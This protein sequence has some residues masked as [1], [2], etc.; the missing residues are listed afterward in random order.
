M[1][2][3]IY[4]DTDSIFFEIPPGVDPIEYSQSIEKAVNEGFAKLSEQLNIKRESLEGQ[5]IYRAELKRVISYFILLNK[6]RY[7]AQ[8]SWEEGIILPE[9][10]WDYKGIKVR[11]DLAQVSYELEKNIPVW[12]ASEYTPQDI[13]NHLKE[14]GQRMLDGGYRLYDT[15]IPS[16]ITKSFKEYTS[17]CSKKACAKARMTT[18]VPRKDSQETEPYFE[19]PKCKVKKHFT[20]SVRAA[21]YSDRYL[22]LAFFPGTKGR[23]LYIKNVPEK[24]PPTDAILIYKDTV[25]DP[26]FKID[27]ERMWEATILAHTE[28]F[29]HILGLPKEAVYPDV[30]VKKKE[31]KPLVETPLIPK[32]RT[33]KKKAVDDVQKGLLGY[34]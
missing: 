10:D 28:D 22:G 20:A 2:K 7:A 25:V 17:T 9:A 5:S 19:C 32:T 8:Y 24:Y 15:A 21:Y 29:L 18:I 30:L 33:R 12:I 14:M 16:R 23:R 27:W 11:S 31:E 6:K 1:A 3:I 13:A 4:G 34:V 26:A